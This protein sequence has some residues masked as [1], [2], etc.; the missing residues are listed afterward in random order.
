VLEFEAIARIDS[1]VEIAYYRNG[2]ILQTVLK[3]LA[4][5]AA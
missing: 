2:G 1:P 5:P 4:Q 3:R